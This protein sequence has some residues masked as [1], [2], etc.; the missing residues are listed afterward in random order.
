MDKKQFPKQKSFLLYR[1]F[2]DHLDKLTMEERAIWI[3]NIFYYVND[4]ELMEMSRLVDLI[5][6]IVKDQIDRDAEE[7]QKSVERNR[8]NGKKGGRPKKKAAPKPS[9]YFK[10]Q[11]KADTDT[12][13]ETATENDTGAV[14]KEEDF[15]TPHTQTPPA[16]ERKQYAAYVSLSEEEYRTLCEMFGK[17]PTDRMIEIVSD[18][19]GLR[20]ENYQ[21]YRDFYAIKTWGKERYDKQMAKQS[22]VTHPTAYP[23][24]YDIGELETFWNQH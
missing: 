2:V 10:N 22:E 11:Q 5:F 19:K 17:Q 16:V 9:G 7:Y 3:T 14:I 8:E 4:R 18:H 15:H 12:K 21:N 20:P 23:S 6:S 24:S 1:D 13:T